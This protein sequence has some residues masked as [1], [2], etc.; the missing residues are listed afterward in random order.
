[1]YEERAFYSTGLYW[2]EKSGKILSLN[3]FF[4]LWTAEQMKS[5]LNF[6]KLNMQN[7]KKIFI[8]QLF[9]NIFLSFPLLADRI[10]ITTVHPAAA[11]LS[12]I[13]GSR[14]RVER[15]IPPG[16]S[17]HTYEARPSDMVKI[18]RSKGI[19]YISAEM[20]GWAAMDKSIKSF[21]MISFLPENQRLSLVHGHS[22]GKNHSSGNEDPHFW[23]DP[24]SVKA[25]LP[26]LTEALCS[27]DREGCSVYTVNAGNFAKKLTELDQKIKYSLRASEGKK[28][29]LYHPSFRYYFKRYGLIEA[30]TLEPVAGGEPSA[31]HIGNIISTVKTKNVSAILQEP[32]FSSSM[33]KLVAGETGI[34][35]I[36]IDP[37][38]GVSG[39]ITYE[40]LLMFNTQA[41]SRAPR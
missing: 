33:A 5:C 28:F 31:R 17:P 35:V 19:F 38:G 1:M 6:K 34:P 14:S 8:I 2:P 7:I 37:T 36:T 30:G 40:E 9:F 3:K 4:N 39:R 13:T 26:G 32:Q 20:D 12:E 29:I 10:F 22:H 18:K 41:F 25:V 21:E 24:L 27:R 16:I 11:I 15:L 23:T